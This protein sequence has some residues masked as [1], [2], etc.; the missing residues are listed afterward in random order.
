M[1]LTLTAA[2]ARDHAAVQRTNDW[3]R[4]HQQ[5]RARRTVVGGRVEFG[6][7]I[8]AACKTAPAQMRMRAAA[9]MPGFAN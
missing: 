5:V 7:G 3:K 6:T 2:R 9:R 4:L 8:S 1:R